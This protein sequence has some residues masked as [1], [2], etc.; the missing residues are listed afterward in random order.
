MLWNNSHHYSIQCAGVCMHDRDTLAFVFCLSWC[1]IP[2]T[3]FYHQMKA[4]AV[5]YCRVAYI[6][7]SNSLLQNYPP[8]M[9]LNLFDWIDPLRSQTWL[10][11]VL[12]QTVFIRTWQDPAE[13]AFCWDSVISPYA[14]L[15][16][17][18]FVTWQ[19][20]AY[21]NECWGVCLGGFCPYAC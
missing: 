16:V 9:P 4:L 3:L 12:W 13:A 21:L 7:D 11:F 18:R 19:H 5:K 20:S 6:S 2:E 10:I 1:Y 17:S 14:E 15:T 8:N